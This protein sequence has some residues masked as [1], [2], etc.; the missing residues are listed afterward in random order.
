MFY[1]YHRSKKGKPIETDLPILKKRYHT[2]LMGMKHVFYRSVL[3]KKSH[4]NHAINGWNNAG[5][6]LYIAKATNAMSIVKKKEP[7]M[8]LIT[9]W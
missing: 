3:Q 1:I 6:I 9:I 5:A 2:K 8:S 7:R 4:L